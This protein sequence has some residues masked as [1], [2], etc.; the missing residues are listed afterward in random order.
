VS[1]ILTLSFALVGLGI[2]PAVASAQAP[3][4]AFE[5]DVL[6]ILEKN[7][8][9]CHRAPYQDKNGVLKT[10]KGKLRLDGREWIEK[11]G[12]SGRVVVAG[13]PEQSPIYTRTVLPEDDEDRMPNEGDPLTKEQTETIKLWVA[14]GGDFGKWTGAAGPA[15]GE[16][17]EEVERPDP[18][19]QEL[20]KGLAPLADAVVQKAAGKLARIT[21]IATGSPLLRVEYLGHDPQVRDAELEALVPLRE[22]VLELSLART[23][24]TDTA[25]ALVA[26]MPRLVRLDLRETGVTEA[27]VAKVA[28]L[29]EL[30]S[31]NLFGTQVGD[32]AADALAKAP[33]LEAVYVWQSKVSD[34]GIAK[35]K[36]ALP[37]AKVVGA[38]ELPAGALEA[39]RRGRRTK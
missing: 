29:P 1:R 28:A 8:V 27:G 5:K 10:P 38:P 25:L 34:D 22:H 35:L 16:K 17:R 36:Q 2:A 33:K 26:K 20:E 6:P 9:E 37:K 24:I 30:R 18:L 3:A 19:R 7:C 11:G 4:V 14:A 32:G 21:R 13:K 39:G 15:A 31:L 12:E 23:K